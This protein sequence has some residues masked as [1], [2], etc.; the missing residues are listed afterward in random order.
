MKLPRGKRLLW[1]GLLTAGMAVVLTAAARFLGPAASRAHS[2]RNGAGSILVKTVLP[3]KDKAFV[4]AI[5][6]PA[7]VEAFYRADLFAHV[8]GPVKYVE[9]DIGDTVTGGEL[10]VEIDVPDLI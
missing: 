4:R 2:A 7:Y 10:L 1:S 5:T 6:G 9:K 3:K 8:A